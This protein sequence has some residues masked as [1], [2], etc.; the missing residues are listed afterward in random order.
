MSISGT[1]IDVALALYAAIGVIYGILLAEIVIAA[2]SDYQNAK[3]AT[4]REAAALIDIIRLAR[5]FDEV[6][7][8]AI[9]EAVKQYACTVLKVEWP[10][11]ENGEDIDNKAIE[12]IFDRGEE[13]LDELFRLYLE[14][15]KETKRE[16]SA[17]AA[18]RV[19]PEAVSASLDEIDE[20]GDARQARIFAY[21]EHI[22]GFMWLVVLV[23]GGLLVAF[24]IRFDA[25]KN[26]AAH[27][28]S[29]YL[30][31]VLLVFLFASIY[32]WDHPFEK[33]AD[34]D[35]TD[36]E[37]VAKRAASALGENPLETCNS[38]VSN[39]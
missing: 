25:E 10:Q 2:W 37:R 36:F 20:L 24:S 6:K 32:F 30:L 33:P 4:F 26:D 16:N 13:I 38:L 18:V 39:N 12:K 15:V 35:P 7:R 28:W 19:S 17:N 11:M 34:V 1:D 5:A 31:I 23:G 3:A 21:R 9:C 8:R 29:I 14:P 27:L 22:P